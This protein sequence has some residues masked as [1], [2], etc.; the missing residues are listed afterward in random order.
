MEKLGL[1]E[2][3]EKYVQNAKRLEELQYEDEKAEAM[4]HGEVAELTQKYIQ[5]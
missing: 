5:G 3:L 4:F 1:K 2:S